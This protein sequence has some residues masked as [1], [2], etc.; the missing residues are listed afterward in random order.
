MRILSFLFVAFI[1]TAGSC[2]KNF[3]PDGVLTDSKTATALKK[4][5]KT[6][7]IEGKKLE[8]SAELWRDFMPGVGDAEKSLRAAVSISVNGDADLP[9]NLSFIKLVVIHSD[10]L[11]IQSIVN[12][13]RS[14]A[15]RLK[16]NT[17]GGPEWKPES[18][19]DVV[20]EFSHMDKLYKLRQEMVEIRATY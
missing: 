19:A 3:P 14:D 20:V 16:A 17:Q 18:K 10:S 15:I 8:L 2:E 1:L 7:L 11:W 9:M 13:E 6:V 5:P 12:S 4:V